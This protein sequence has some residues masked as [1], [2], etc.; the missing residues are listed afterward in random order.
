[1][2]HIWPAL[3]LLFPLLLSAQEKHDPRHLVKIGDPAPDFTMRY[4]DGKNVQLSDLR[5][6]V[7]MLQ[8]TASWCSVCRKEMPHIEREIWNKHKDRA[9]FVLV[10]V[11]LKE[12]TA[13]IKRF[14]KATGISYPVILDP[15]GSIFDLY[16]E[17]GAGVTRNVII[18]KEG[19]IA[20]LTRLFE[21]EEFNKMKS[22]IEELL[23]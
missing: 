5:G 1:M 2:K 13:K 7:I 17:K 16:A 14:I 10:A 12:D 11:D 9:D 22:V 20:F 8:F 4:I 21:R 19:K 23:Q 3:F 15:E 18:D 6:K